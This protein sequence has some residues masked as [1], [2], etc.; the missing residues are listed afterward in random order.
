MR[1]D[2]ISKKPQLKENAENVFNV[3]SDIKF[4]S[5]QMSEHALFLH[6][7]LSDEKLKK[8]G[9]KLNAKWEKFRK[10]DH[11]IKK[12]IPLLDELRKYKVSVLD[13]LNKGE[14]IG[15]NFPLLVDHM[16]RELD[17]LREKI[18]GKIHTS[19]EEL[20]FW[21]EINADHSDFTAHLLDP[22]EE[23]LINTALSTAKNMREVKTLKI[24]LTQSKALDKFVETGVDGVKNNKIKSIIPIELIEHVERE[25]KRSIETFEALLKK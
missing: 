20:S 18:D 17:Y 7:G 16:I 15:Y 6:L 8:Q 13:R 5:E 9:M 1:L 25:G 12:I 24:G 3:D 4:W 19:E 11:D 2:E 23:D 10:T 21:I 14:W 22:T